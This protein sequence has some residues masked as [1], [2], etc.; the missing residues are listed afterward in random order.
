METAPSTPRNL[1]VDDETNLLSPHMERLD[2]TPKDTEV[3]ELDS[4]PTTILRQQIK[5]NQKHANRRSIR[6]YGKQR[7]VQVFRVGEKVSVAVPKID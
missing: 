6:Q 3:P 7:S 5:E 4:V 2:L 1:A